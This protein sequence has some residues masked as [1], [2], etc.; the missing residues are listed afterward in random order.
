LIFHWSSPDRVEK[1]VLVP[2][3]VRLGKT[4]SATEAH[5]IKEERMKLALSGRE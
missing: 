1:M 3:C 4:G 5:T 2:V